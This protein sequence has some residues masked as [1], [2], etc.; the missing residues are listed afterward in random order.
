MNS[1]QVKAHNNSDLFPGELEIFMHLN[2]LN[3]E[4]PIVQVETSNERSIQAF[5]TSFKFA[6][7]RDFEVIVDAEGRINYTKLLTQISSLFGRENSAQIQWPQIR[8]LLQKEIIRFQ[9]P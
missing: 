7:A 4:K 9:R 1:N 2:D 6:K 8:P 3:E 5:G